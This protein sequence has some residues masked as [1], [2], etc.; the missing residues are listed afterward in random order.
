MI[1][2]LAVIQ[3][4]TFGANRYNIYDRIA[5]LGRNDPPDSMNTISSRSA[6]YICDTELCSSTGQ[7]S[8]TLPPYQNKQLAD[9]ISNSEA[10][11]TKQ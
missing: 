8:C 6:V 10:M 7:T 11:T 4:E 5:F 2:S 1:Q 3:T 9:G